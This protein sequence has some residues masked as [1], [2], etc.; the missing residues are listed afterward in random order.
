MSY[1]LTQSELEDLVVDFVDKNG[2][3]SFHELRRLL[4]DHMPVDGDVAWSCVPNVFVWFN[5]SPEFVDLLR[6]LYCQKRIY[7]HAGSVWAH[8]ADGGAPGLPLATKVTAKG[9]RKPH[10]LP[11]TWCTF[12]M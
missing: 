6:R 1:T 2:Y 11:T 10:W 8:V 12:P 3:A 7:P 5:M 9:Y 4:R